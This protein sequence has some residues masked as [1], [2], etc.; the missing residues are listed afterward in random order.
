[1][2]SSALELALKKQRLQIAGEGLRSDFARHATG[3][4]PLFVGADMAVVGAQWVRRNP[5]LVVAA[6]V[7][8]LVIRPRSAIGWARRAFIGWRIWRNFR[9]FMERRLPPHR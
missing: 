7:A 4:M 5:Q 6:G 3:L 8:L 2:E 1:M 9:D